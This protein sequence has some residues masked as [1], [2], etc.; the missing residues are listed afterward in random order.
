MQRLGWK[1]DLI[2][3]V[4]ARVH[5]PAVSAPG[6]ASWSG[7]SATHSQYRHVQVKGRFLHG[8]QTFVLTTTHKGRGFWV[9][10]P[11]QTQRGF[12]VLVNRGFVPANHLGTPE[13]QVPAPQ[14][15][16][17]VTGLLR[18]TESGGA[19]LRPNKPAHNRWYSRDV[20]AI[21]KHDGLASDSVAPYFIDADATPGSSGPPTGGLTKIHF[22][23]AHLQYAITWYVLALLVVI[24]AVIVTR[25]ERRKRRHAAD[26]EQRG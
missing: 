13:A 16:V 23:N 8:E 26:P 7:I 2:A 4:N 24:C 20:A 17:R 18:I 5:A 1:L 6:P 11:L 25:Y 14:Q 22:R 12:I 10:A 3:R 21:A 15:P 19:F 9:M